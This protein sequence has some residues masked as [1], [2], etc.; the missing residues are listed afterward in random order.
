MLC[1]TW[2]SHLDLS[3]TWGI[4]DDIRHTPVWAA[5]S[6]LTFPFMDFHDFVLFINTTFHVCVCVN[7]RDVTDTF[8]FMQL[9]RIPP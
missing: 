6:D 9:R 4:S 3:D 5:K 7:V 1:H 8:R 2:Q